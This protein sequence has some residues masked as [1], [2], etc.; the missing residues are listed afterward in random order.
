MGYVVRKRDEELAKRAGFGFA[1]KVPFVFHSETGYHTEASEY[2]ID[3]ATSVWIPGKEPSGWDPTT[4][5]MRTYS[6]ALCNFLD[7]T[8]AREVST[9]ECTYAEHILGM[10]QPDMLRGYWS[11]KNE[12]LSPSTVNGRV[13]TACDY[14]KWLA[15]KGYRDS[16]FTVITRTTK[17]RVGGRWGNGTKSTR[18]VTRRV[19]HLRTQKSMLVMPT[20]TQVN[21]W[22]RSV[23]ARSGP[24]FELMCKTVCLCAPREAE[25][26]GM[27]LA[28]I[29]E[30]NRGWRISNPT[31]PRANQEHLMRL[32]YGVKGH[33]LGFD[34]GDKVSDR[35]RTIRVPRELVQEWQRYVGRER[36]DALEIL[37]DSAATRVER[38][39]LQADAV[40]LFLHP[41]TGLRIDP[42]QIYV[43]WKGG[44]L[45]FPEWTVHMGRD[46]W[47]CSTLLREVQRNEIV[48]KLGK[49]M[50]T[51][52]LEATAISIIRLII[53]P[54]LG[55]VSEQTTFL[56]LQWIAGIY[57]VP[58][59][60]R[61]DK[62]L[63]GEMPEEMR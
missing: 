9:L 32:L 44:E 62:Y 38:E 6:K 55:H 34:H 47:A 20:L 30:G 7:W 35:P 39:Q 33:E 4:E 25:L 42:N 22:L 10:Y 60:L 27:R 18:E 23:K 26:V 37:L 61:W 28:D 8:D 46:W 14:L 63:E 40:H 15:A 11:E 51:Q 57:S 53:Q 50:T 41:K 3:R 56:Y 5:S 36:T 13:R 24:T 52:L 59:S 2:L 58:L 45:P 19:G 12:P 1:A 16:A 21:R 49:N 17:V 29:P 31:A 48:A 54:Q 43:A